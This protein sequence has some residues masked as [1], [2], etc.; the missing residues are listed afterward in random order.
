MGIKFKFN[1]N[2]IG[3]NSS[4]ILITS[5]VGHSPVMYVVSFK[6]LLNRLVLVLPPPK[7]KIPLACLLVVLLGVQSHSKIKQSTTK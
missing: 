2:Y 6:L 7:K 1:R 4:A 5:N 3:K